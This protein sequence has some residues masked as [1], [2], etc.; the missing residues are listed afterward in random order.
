MKSLEL[1][2]GMNPH[3]APA[4]VRCKEGELPFEILNGSPGFINLLDALNAWQLVKELKTATGLP[5]AASFKHVSPAGAAVAVP[6]TPELE[7]S[8]FVEGIELSDVAVAYVRARGADR[9]SSYGDLVAVSDTVDAS[10]ARYLK[11]EVSDGIIAPGYDDDA[12]EILRQKKKGRYLVLKMDLDYAAPETETR[13]VFGIVLEQRRNDCVV[14]EK[15]FENIV[16]ENKDMPEAA[17]RDL[18][19][20]TLT[21]KYTQSNSVCFACD[22][23]VIGNGAGQQSRIHCVRLAASKADMWFLRQHPSVVD[24]PFREGLSR[25]EINNAVDGFLSDDLTDVEQRYLQELFTSMP[26]RPGRE[27]KR[28]WL[29]SVS[30]VSMSSDAYFPFRDSIDRAAQSGVKYIVEPGGSIRDDAVIEAA[31]AYGM[32]MAFSGLRLFHH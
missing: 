25:P 18:L 19:V 5:A 23:Q 4:M 3:Q 12:L 1:R 17:K 8:Y 10:L 30:G 11:L 20:A 9:V 32:V 15:L 14:S 28:E 13:E 7:K 26:A 6:L 29:S 27:Q 31:N 22:G 24:L 16:T 2:Y 21:L